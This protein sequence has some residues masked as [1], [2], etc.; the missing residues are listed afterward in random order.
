M[1]KKP[2]AIFGVFAAICIVA[3]PLWTISK[4]GSEESVEAPVAAADEEGKEM[5]ATNCGPC[6]TLEAAGT[7]GVVGP[8]LDESKP[9]KELVI[10]RV[11]NGQGAMPAFGD[12]YSAEEIEAVADYV[13]ASTGQ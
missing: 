11:T 1:H 8:N 3:I 7:D 2:F 4:E 10:D 12:N 13:V 9:P 6:H 5:F